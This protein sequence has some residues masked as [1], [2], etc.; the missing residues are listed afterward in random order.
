MRRHGFE[1][2]RVYAP[3]PDERGTQVVIPLDDPSAVRYFLQHL[4]RKDSRLVRAAIVGAGLL[5]KLGALRAA[6]PYWFLYFT[7]DEA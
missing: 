5:L 7:T 3:L 2:P 4:V 1:R 6:L